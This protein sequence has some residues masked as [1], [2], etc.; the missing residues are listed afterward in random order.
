MANTENIK[1]KYKPGNLRNSHIKIPLQGNKTV[2]QSGDT[3]KKKNAL[4]AQFSF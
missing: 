4:F 3:T 2:I 1:E